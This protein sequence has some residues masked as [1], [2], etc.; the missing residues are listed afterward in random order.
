MFNV[1]QIASNTDL[2]LKIVIIVCGS[3][4]LNYISRKVFTRVFAKTNQPRTRT[5][6]SVVQNATSIIILAI[7][8]LTLLAALNINIMPLLAS[9][10]IFGFAI[11]FGSQSLI[12]DLISGMFL[13]TSDAFYEGD[14]V[15]IGTIE[16]KVERV[17]IRA[18]TIRDLEGVVHTIPNG[19]IATVANLT[20]E[21]SRANITIGVSVE[22][23][24]DKVLKVFKEEL[25][26]LKNDPTFAGWI[27][28]SPKV[29]GIEKIDGAKIIVKTLLK[30]NQAKKWDM[31]REFNY[32]IK[33]R[34]EK[35]KL[36]FA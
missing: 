23:D 2:W 5:V 12:K 18:V 3:Y 7:A 35:E 28:G 15:R 13:L 33:K 21:W 16:G 8:I 34:F 14:I 4:V 1:T 31:E 25:Q 27:L 9:A 10:G 29:E 32:R 36:K 26:E 30:T 22:H 11:G 20:R 24:I 6:L 17:S 19:T